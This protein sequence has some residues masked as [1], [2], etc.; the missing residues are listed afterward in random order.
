MAKITFILAATLASIAH[1][2][3]A[4]SQTMC[5]IE[6]P[7][8]RVRFTSCSASSIDR[9][10]KDWIAI[11]GKV[12]E[13]GAGAYCKSRVSVDVLQAS[14]KEPPSPMN[15]DFDPCLIWTVQRGDLVN[16]YVWE[17]A[18]P[19]TGAYTLARCPN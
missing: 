11:S 14:M 9:P 16:V 8:E 12:I 15:I 13:S 19:N 3:S 10:H 6:C 7:R 2:S 18:S 5:S 17:R 4:M 1:V